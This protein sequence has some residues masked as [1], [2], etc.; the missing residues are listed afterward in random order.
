[1]V[2]GGDFRQVLPVIRFENRSD[3]IAASLKSSNLWSYFNVMHLNQNMRTGPGEEEFSKWLIKLGNGELPS[4]EYDEI[5]LP[6]S[7]MLDGNLVD[8]IFWQCISI[9][10]IPTLCNRTILCPKNEHS[11]LV[12][13]EVLQRL[14]GKEIVY[15]SMDDVECEDG[16]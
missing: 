10:D 4:N 2:L 15:T 12:N 8:E 6:G 1:M 7:C 5:E 11:L 16:D 13:E 3:L 9:N 14:P